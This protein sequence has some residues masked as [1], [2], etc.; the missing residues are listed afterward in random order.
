M[1]RKANL[2]DRSEF[3][4]GELVICKQSDKQHWPA[5]ITKVDQNASL[6]SKRYT[7]K[8]F[9][10]GKVEVVN[11]KHLFPYK[12]NR[13]FVDNYQEIVDF[14]HAWREIENEFKADDH[15]PVLSHK[16]H[17]GKAEGKESHGDSN[18]G[19]S[20]HSKHGGS[21]HGGSSHSKH[22]K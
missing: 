12:E 5:Q 16:S 19:G 20:S 2:L 4:E 15:L 21:S 13:D 18:H 22:K 10:T 8:H 3:W 14:V 11:K 1:G 17:H 7:V 6:N 9:V